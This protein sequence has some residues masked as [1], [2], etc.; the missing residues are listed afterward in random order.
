VRSHSN[1]LKR[2]DDIFLPEHLD[3]FYTLDRFHINGSRILSRSFQVEYFVGEEE[4]KGTAS[5]SVDPEP[6]G[7]DA[8]M[9][10]KTE[11]EDTTDT[12]ELGEDEREGITDVAMAPMADVLNARNRCDNVR[13]LLFDSRS[14]LTSPQARLFYDKDSLNMVAVRPIKCGEQIWNTYGDLPNADLLRRYG[15]VDTTPLEQGGLFPYGNSSDDVEIPADLIF[16][17]CLSGTGEEQKTCRIDAWMS[18][19]DPEE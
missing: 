2:R 13:F 12:E 4:E 10:Q 15:H 3:S 7:T 9:Q 11:E 19:D 6:V 17:I 16:D 18:L 14:T 8:Q 1:I 5:M